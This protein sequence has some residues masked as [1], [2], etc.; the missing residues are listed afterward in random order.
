MK[1]LLLVIGALLLLPVPVSAQA[2]V[3]DFTDAFTRADAADIGANWDSGY[4]TYDPFQIVSN[5]VQATT[6]SDTANAETV[7]AFSPAVNQW[8]QVTLA[9]VVAGNT[10][11]LSVLLRAATVPTAT[12]YECTAVPLPDTYH[13]R[14]VY[15]LSGTN[16]A[17]VT[18]TAVT[19]VQG[20]VL[21]CEVIGTNLTL[22]Q[23][24]VSVLTFSNAA[25]ASGKVGLYLQQRESV[26]EFE[27]D[28]FSAGHYAS[29]GGA[30]LLLTGVAP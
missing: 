30:S 20:D 25:L 11:S 2:R 15:R 6:G 12:W 29:A 5:R 4:T 14:I 17:S 16:M 1:R 26:N 10:S 8:A 18:E 13:S 22:Y 27:A 9:T 23:N 28:D 3:A 24:D 21:R 7:N 19:W